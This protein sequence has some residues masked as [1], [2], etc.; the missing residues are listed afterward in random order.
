MHYVEG[1]LRMYHLLTILT[2]AAGVFF[3]LLFPLLRKESTIFA[4]ASVAAGIAII[5]ACLTIIL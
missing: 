5:I 2:L 3:I 4:Y 1:I